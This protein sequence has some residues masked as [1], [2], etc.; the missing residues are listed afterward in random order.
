MTVSF[1]IIAT[2]PGAVGCL[3]GI[4]LFGEI[5]GIRNFIF[6]GAAVLLNAIGVALIT[7]GKSVEV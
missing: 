5:R 7:V 2:G 3:W 4:L 6:F 1:P